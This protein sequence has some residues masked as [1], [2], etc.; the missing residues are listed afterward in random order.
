MH[1]E[2]LA[3]DQSGKTALDILVPKII[4]EAHTFRVHSYKGIGHIPKNMRDAKEASKRILLNNLPK[5]LKGYGRAFAGYPEN[6]SAAVIF[7]CDLD[8]KCLKNFRNELLEILD[9]CNPKPE[10]HFCVAIEE[11]EAWLLGDLK[12]VLA[13]YPIAKRNT[14][15][16]YVQD[17]ICGTW[18]LLA[19][20]LFPGGSAA[21]AGLGWQSV[22]AE[23]ANWATAIA[24][25]MDVNDNA[26][27][28]FLYF[29][30]KLSDLTP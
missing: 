1:L 26:S 14:L 19:D 18:E 15:E 17:S 22:G 30:R 29:L 23:K 10:T 24:P 16:S 12:A 8:D 5:L 21:L 27:P 28:S 7:V 25:L 3:E 9:A 2:I 4:G 6:Y 20:A 11:G 13:A